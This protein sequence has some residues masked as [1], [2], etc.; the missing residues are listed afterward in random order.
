MAFDPATGIFTLDSGLLL[1]PTLTRAAFLASPEGQEAGNGC[2]DYHFTTAG[3][4]IGM[5]IFFGTPN[6]RDYVAAHDDRL[7]SVG[8]AATGPPH[9][10]SWEEFTPQKELMRAAAGRA[11]LAA[12]GV[13]LEADGRQ[14]TYP[15]GTVGSYYDHHNLGYSLTLHYARDCRSFEF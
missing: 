6:L 13:K 1:G 9:P 11:W 4:T 10:T 2:R 15:W 5:N 7:T 12:Q 8:F 14:L 3:G